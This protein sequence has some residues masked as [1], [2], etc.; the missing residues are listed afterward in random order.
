MNKIIG[1]I[2]CGNMAQA[3]LG[4][5]IKSHVVEPNKIIASALHEDTLN[6]IKNKYNINTTLCNKEVAKTVDIL[7][8]AVKPYVYQSVIDE[9]KNEIKAD[10][11]IVNIAAGITIK[12][13][14]EMFGKK[15]KIIKAMPN[16]P[17]LVLEGMTALTY[18]EGLTVDEIFTIKTIFSSFG[19]VEVVKENLM[20][21]V[22]AVSG[23]SPAYIFMLIE[24]MAD[25]AVL[26]GMPRSQ[27][28]IFASQ[29]VLGA[30][31]MVLETGEHPGKLKDGVCSPGGTT[32]EAV[33]KLEEKGFRSSII[34]AMNACF[35]K[36]KNMSK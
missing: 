1:F 16:T 17:A 3:M 25:A 23:S 5:M 10:A 31:K 34:E 4:G 35:N 7:I 30:A 19:K 21:V 24:A 2:G 8:L 33:A 13:T 18:N 9:I 28:Y 26:Q 27:S 32:I 14:E 36:S 12:K 11:I 29:A 20:D 15:V 6:T 22:T